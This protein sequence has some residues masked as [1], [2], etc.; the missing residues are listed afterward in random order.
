VLPRAAR[1]PTPLR[2]NKFIGPRFMIPT[3]RA[4]RC[5]P[6]DTDDRVPELKKEF[7]LGGCATSRGAA[8]AWSSPEHINI[9]DNGIIPLKERVVDRYYDPRRDRRPQAAYGIKRRTKSRKEE[10]RRGDEVREVIVSR[11]K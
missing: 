5:I 7:R 4:S 10:R 8:T 11:M 3:W 2:K 9:T 6:L 1:S